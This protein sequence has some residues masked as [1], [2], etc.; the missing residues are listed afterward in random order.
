MTKQE[1]RETIRHAMMYLFDEYA[2]KKQ[3]FYAEYHYE[4]YSLLYDALVNA[5]AAP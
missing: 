5:E 3:V 1:V 4:A 2:D